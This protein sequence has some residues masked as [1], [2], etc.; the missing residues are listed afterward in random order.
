MNEVLAA[1]ASAAEPVTIHYTWRP[2]LRDAGGEL[3]LEAA[4]NGRADTLATYNVRH[5]AEAAARSR[6]P[7]ILSNGELGMLG[8][9]TSGRSLRTPRTSHPSRATKF[10][11][12]CALCWNA[13]L[14]EGNRPR[15][16]AVS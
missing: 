11:T 4:V 16:A 5:F 1:L 8:P 3:V 7:R 9:K 2:Q 12:I 6:R 14:H 10:P 15:V 13:R